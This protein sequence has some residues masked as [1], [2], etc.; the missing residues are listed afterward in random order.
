M[1]LIRKIW[2]NNKNNKLFLLL[3][4]PF[5]SLFDFYRFRFVDEKKFI[6]NNFY[7]NHGYKL[8][9]KDPKTLNEKIQWLKL[10]DRTPLH[11][12]CADKIEV[13]DVIKEKLGEEYLIPMIYQ[14]DDINKLKESDLPNYPVIVKTNHD[15]GNYVIVKDKSKLD[16]I[17]LKKKFKKA[18]KNNYYY[19]TKEWQYKNIKPKV[20]IEKLLMDKDGNIPLDYKIHCIH[21]KVEMISVDLDRGTSFH[22]RN[23]YDKNW[24]KLPLNWSSI[25]NGHKTIQSEKEIPEPI[26]LKEMIA[27]SEKIS[28]LFKYVRVDWYQLGS[29]LYFGE[30][31]FHHDSGMKPIEP[32]EYDLK[33]GAKLNLT[34]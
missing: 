28:S 21:G 4:S 20:I 30:L 17:A 13:R 16:F 34:N 9:L 22:K 18:L 12:Q 10:Y 5:K 23:W 27:N 26:L 24:K 8:N 33:Y 32:R 14:T 1:E 25:I 3:F 6:E 31:T 7:I 11:T 15:S 19:S 29:K 2:I